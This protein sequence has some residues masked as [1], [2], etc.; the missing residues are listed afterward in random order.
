VS[1][2]PNPDLGA[3]PSFVGF[4]G[5]LGGERGASDH[6]RAAYRSDIAQFV[7]HVWGPNRRAPFPWRETTDVESRRFLT[8][9]M[10]SGAGASTARRKLSAVREF[11]RYLQREGVTIDNPFSLLRGP[12][13]AKTLPRTVSPADLDRLLARPLVDF[14][15]GRLNEYPARRDA[16]LFE[17]LYSTGCRIS[18]ALSIVWGAINW[19]DGSIVVLGK[20]RKERLVILGTPA[21]RS[22]RE[23]RKLLAV[24]NPECAD[25]SKPVFLSDRYRPLSARFAQRRMKRYLA[26]ADL[27]GDLSPHKLRHSFATHL[28]D[29][30]ADLRS[31]QEMLGHAS[32]STTQIYTHVSIGRLQDQ[33][34]S[35]HPRA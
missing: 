12:R 29:A 15:E 25:D 16:A 10:A 9:L 33:F 4:D 28:L 13:R 23:L 3:D 6:T 8:A 27:P 2:T 20:G 14:R 11:Y 18:E 7:A 34:L 31:V 5:Y 35:K 30:G 21:L 17:L 26:E 22:L 24:S 19:S 32:L 1:L